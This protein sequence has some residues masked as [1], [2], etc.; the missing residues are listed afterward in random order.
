MSLCICSKAQA[1]SRSDRRHR[2]RLPLLRRF[3]RHRFH[4]RCRVYSLEK[5]GV[6]YFIYLCM[7]PTHKTV[8]SLHNGH[9]K[10]QRVLLAHRQLQGRAT[11]AAQY[12]LPSLFMLWISKNY[13]ATQKDL[14]HR[15]IIAWKLKRRL[16]RAVVSTSEELF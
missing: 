13:L 6:F 4:R 7:K 5:D 3:R 16:H 8:Y 12:M 1:R 2:L 15:T 9:K 11:D 14:T 10:A